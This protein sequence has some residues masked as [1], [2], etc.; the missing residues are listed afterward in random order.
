MLSRDGADP[1]RLVSSGRT[2]ASALADYGLE[3]LGLPG[4]GLAGELL[5]GL[6]GESQSEQTVPVELDMELD[7]DDGRLQVVSGGGT[8]AGFDTGPLAG[9]ITSAIIVQL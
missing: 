1:Y 4:A 8:V 7:S 3:S 6:L 9:L 2:T 5:D